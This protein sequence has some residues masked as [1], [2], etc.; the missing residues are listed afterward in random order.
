MRSL[1][2]RK[3]IVVTGKGGAGKSTLSAALA[4]AASRAGVCTIVVE[5]GGRAVVPGLLEADAERGG[6]RA[7]G[8]AGGASR[9]GGAGEEEVQ[10]GDALWSTSIDPD[11][12]LL[13]WLGIVGGRRAAALLA[14]RA[15]FR[16]LAAA[17]PGANDLLALVRIWELTRGERWERGGRR[18]DLVIVDAPATGHALAMLRAP[19]TFG[20]IARIGPIATQAEGVRALLADPQRT[21]Y[22]A[23]ALPS[24]MAVTETL[25]LADAMRA[26]IGRQPDWV[27]VN[28][29]Y[30]RRF[31]PAELD[32]LARIADPRVKPALDAARFMHER[33][34]RQRA[35]IER[36]RRTGLPL[37][38]L[39]F[40]LRTP[41][42]R[43]AIE[44]LADR[45]TRRLGAP[46]PGTLR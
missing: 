15:S 4:L 17:A 43:A 33:G 10:I 40:V 36:L 25:E 22:L 38:T 23:V 28:A 13:D 35:Q 26:E 2:E 30:P 32:R 39:P 46:A 1:L 7:R 20:A 42:D 3:L 31:T 14:S 34:L 11:R 8:R 19:S 29:T 41:M 5:L 12:A 6:A 37:L 24:E 44:L 9:S 45:L 21:G 27:A 16:Y 18:Y